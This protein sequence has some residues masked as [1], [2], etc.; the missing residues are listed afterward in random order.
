MS[1][2]EK[3]SHQLKKFM[4]PRNPYRKYPSFKDLAVK[5]PSFREHCTYD[6]SG[7]VYL[8]FSNPLALKALTT[9]L[10]DNDFNLK[11]TSFYTISYIFKYIRRKLYE[12]KIIKY[13]NCN[14]KN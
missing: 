13:C 14:Q 5:Y 12:N 10:L 7:K 6:I 4:H 2:K 1:S 3:P 8:D 11:V 9:C